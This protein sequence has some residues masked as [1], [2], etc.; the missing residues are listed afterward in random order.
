MTLAQG[1]GFQAH[2]R[3]AELRLDKTPKGRP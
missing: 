2:A 3:S 1:E